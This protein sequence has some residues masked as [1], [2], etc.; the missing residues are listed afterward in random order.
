MEQIESTH[1]LGDPGFSKGKKFTDDILQRTGDLH[2]HAFF[3]EDSQASELDNTSSDDEASG[4]KMLA[5]RK[6]MRTKYQ[7]NSAMKLH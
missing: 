6:G 5:K 1:G 2:E 4:Q 7:I 3:S